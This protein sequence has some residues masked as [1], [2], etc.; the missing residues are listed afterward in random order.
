MAR[1]RHADLGGIGGAMVTTGV[2]NVCRPTREVIS[3]L[4][5]V[6]FIKFSLTE[7]VSSA[8]MEL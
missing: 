4:G 3:D 5:V 8:K 1:N 6:F 7:E 2:Q